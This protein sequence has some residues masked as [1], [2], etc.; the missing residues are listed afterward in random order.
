MSKLTGLS[1]AEVITRHSFSRSV[2]VRVS[3]PLMIGRA[4]VRVCECGS[5]FDTFD[6]W[7]VHIAEILYPPE[8]WNDANPA[9][10]PQ[11]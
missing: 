9:V 7:A 10:P 2:E 4:F 5:Q 8:G 3:N 1:V 11:R 6:D